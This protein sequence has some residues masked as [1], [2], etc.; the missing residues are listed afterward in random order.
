LAQIAAQQV[1]Y[2]GSLERALDD[3]VHAQTEAYAMPPGPKKDEA[4][5]NANLI[6]GA[7]NAI[8]EG[9]DKPH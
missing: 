7:L 9:R 1:E 2:S 5:T 8:A 6:L 3:A 4:L